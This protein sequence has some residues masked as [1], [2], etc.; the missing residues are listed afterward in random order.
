MSLETKDHSQTRDRFSYIG[1]LILVVFIPSVVFLV[2]LGLT[3]QP[4]V[5]FSIEVISKIT[6]PIEGL[7]ELENH[8]FV[9]S[10]TGFMIFIVVLTAILSYFADKTANY[11]GIDLNKYKTCKCCKKQMKDHPKN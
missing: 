5:D 7:D 9:I 10:L 1:I 11:F 8:R 6:E 2:F 3:F 4:L